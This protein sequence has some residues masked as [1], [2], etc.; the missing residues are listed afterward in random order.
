MGRTEREPRYTP[1]E[2]MNLFYEFMRDKHVRERMNKDDIRWW[3][4]TELTIRFIG[5]VRHYH[6]D[7]RMKEFDKELKRLQELAEQRK[8][9]QE[10]PLTPLKEV[11]E[12]SMR[13]TQQNFGEI[14]DG[15]LFD[16]E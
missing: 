13:K 6:L 4:D 15:T 16:P 9:A 2:I 10:K 3:Q 1:T 11:L 5:Y 7:Q 14:T 12:R 8:R